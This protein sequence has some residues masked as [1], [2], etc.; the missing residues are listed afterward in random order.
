M[1][2]TLSPPQVSTEQWRKDN[3]VRCL[4]DALELPQPNGISRQGIRIAAGKFT[5]YVPMYPW[6]E[7]IQLGQGVESW[8]AFYAPGLTWASLLFRES[9]REAIYSYNAAHVA[10]IAHVLCPRKHTNRKSHSCRMPPRAAMSH[11]LLPI[12]Y[13]L[14][15][16]RVQQNY[17]RRPMGE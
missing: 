17:F 1:R 12:G 16:G 7:Y 6:G 3:C 13:R 14:A 9:L 4:S 10:H 8:V 2:A 15:S 5:Q 11:V